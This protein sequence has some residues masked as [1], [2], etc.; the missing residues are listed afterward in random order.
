MKIWNLELNCGTFGVLV[1]FFFFFLILF[2]NLVDDWIMWLLD[3]I[4]VILLGE[5]RKFGILN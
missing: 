4:V 5:W 3:S 1:E 2:K